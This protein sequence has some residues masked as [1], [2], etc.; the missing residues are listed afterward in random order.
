MIAALVRTD[1]VRA[2]KD[3]IEPE[4][5]PCCRRRICVTPDQWR[6]A[7]PE[8][9]RSTEHSKGLL[10]EIGAA[11]GVEHRLVGCCGPIGLRPPTRVA[12]RYG[13]KSRSTKVYVQI[14]ATWQ[15]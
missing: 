5:E 4:F 15:G 3:H 14:K 13:G 2:S 6:D 8:S 7:N 11:S 10:N 1:L 12:W 9:H